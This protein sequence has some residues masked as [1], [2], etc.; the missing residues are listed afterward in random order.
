MKNILY[1][2]VGVFSFCILATSAAANCKSDSALQNE[3]SSKINPLKSGDFCA[4]VDH[5]AVMAA[6]MEEIIAVTQRLEACPG[7]Y[8]YTP[9]SELRSYRDR[10]ADDAKAACQAK[11]D[12]ADMQAALKD[13]ETEAAKQKKEAQEAQQ[14]ASTYNQ[15]SAKVNTVDAL[16]RMG[17]VDNLRAAAALEREAAGL[18]RSIGDEAGQ[19]MALNRA[20]DFDR[21]A[22]LASPAL[23]STAKP[24]KR[25]AEACVQALDHMKKLQA[26]GADTT[27]LNQKLT[28][29]GCSH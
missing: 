1:G 3:L 29:L 10:F 24:Q 27:E 4:L 25:S 26:S 28:A 5:Q 8:G 19:K 15:V 2:F 23:T 9:S 20:L 17:G 22:S 16:E 12:N 13:L 14:N 11:R 18:L 21:R 6:L 7:F